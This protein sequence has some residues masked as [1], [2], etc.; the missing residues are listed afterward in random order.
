MSNPDIVIKTVEENDAIISSVLLKGTLN[1]F[2]AENIYKELDKVA[3]S[4]TDISI[5][6]NDNDDSDLSM[7]QVLYAFKNYTLSKGIKS[8]I[9][10]IPAPKNA[11]LIEHAG[12]NELVKSI[13][14]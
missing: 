2:G 9:N 14:K 12:L 13:N 1:L 10:Y 11:V 4:A 6:V 8:K 3:E 5:E 7:L